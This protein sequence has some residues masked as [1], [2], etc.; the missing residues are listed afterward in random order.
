M[1]PFQF[2][3][4]GSTGTMETQIARQIAAG[5]TQM[6]A[7]PTT[8]QYIIVYQIDWDGAIPT[9]KLTFGDGSAIEGTDRIALNEAGLQ[10]GTH[11]FPNGFHCGL[12][13]A[14]SML[15]ANGGDGV[16]AWAKIT[17]TLS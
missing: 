7:A 6:I 3:V 10:S 1:Q 2:N 4:M 15:I 11:V 14:F 12:G 8:P 9:Q 13:K 16:S 17:Y 5:T